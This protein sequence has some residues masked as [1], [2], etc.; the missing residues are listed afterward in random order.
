MICIEWEFQWD[1]EKFSG[2]LLLQFLFYVAKN[3]YKISSKTVRCFYLYRNYEINH[4]ISS[5]KVKNQQHF[6]RWTQIFRK[7]FWIIFKTNHFLFPSK[8]L[9]DIFKNLFELFLR[10]TTPLAFQESF[11]KII[12][13][14][15]RNSYQIFF[16][17]NSVQVFHSEHSLDLSENT[18]LEFPWNFY[19][20]SR[21]MFLWFFVKVFF[22]NWLFF[23]L[24]V[25]FFNYLI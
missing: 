2:E 1:F 9:T 15:F 6:F 18:W 16:F 21:K 17:Q 11:Q 23:F 3:Y 22:Q 25:I 19:E 8:I 5:K 20:I 14:P 4:F 24:P 12:E 10:A 7:Y 13:V